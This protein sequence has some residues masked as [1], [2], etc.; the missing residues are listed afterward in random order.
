MS[1]L[2]LRFQVPDDEL[3]LGCGFR[4]GNCLICVAPDSR[5]LSAPSMVVLDHGREI[6][7]H[8]R[9]CIYDNDGTAAGPSR[10]LAMLL[11]DSEADFMPDLSVK[12]ALQADVGAQVRVRLHNES[13]KGRIVVRERALGNFRYFV[14]LSDGQV[15]EGAPVFLD[16][17]KNLIGI[18]VGSGPGYVTVL[19][20]EPATNP[21]RLFSRENH[22]RGPVREAYRS[23]LADPIPRREQ[24]SGFDLSQ[25]FLPEADH[26]RL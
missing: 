8:T 18:V 26:Q 22:L 2:R 4:F 23:L 16:D 3:L 12:F 10:A 19:G 17:D 6:Q 13:A 5:V 1:A 11:E 14:S 25:L 15:F 9:L 21:T 7:V 20:L 24:H